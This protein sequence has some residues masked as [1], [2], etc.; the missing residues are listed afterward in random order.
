MEDVEV[1]FKDILEH[2][3]PEIY[4]YLKNAVRMLERQQNLLSKLKNI[5]NNSSSDFKVILS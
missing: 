4:E 5:K 1:P 3:Y 2:E